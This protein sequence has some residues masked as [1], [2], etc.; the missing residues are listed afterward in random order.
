MSLSWKPSFDRQNNEIDLAY[1]IAE[2]HRELSNSTSTSTSDAATQT[3]INT[4]RWQWQRGGGGG[5]VEVAAV[6][7]R[8]KA[9]KHRYRSGYSTTSRM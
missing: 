6:I 5:E 7:E 8:S 9:D 4:Y 3:Q 1:S 2:K